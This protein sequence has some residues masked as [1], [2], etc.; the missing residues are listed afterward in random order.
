[1]AIVHDRPSTP[2]NGYQLIETIIVYKFPN[3]RIEEMQAMFGLSDIKQTRVYQEGVEEGERKANLKAI[4]RFLALG[5][6]VEQIA[7][8]LDLSIEEV[9]QATL[10]QP[11]DQGDK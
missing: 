3:M 5:L 10:Q 2:L 9:K 4:R 8:G 7:E 6:S 11:D 1:M